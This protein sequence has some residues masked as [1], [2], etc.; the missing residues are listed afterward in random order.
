MAEV[1]ELCVEK[2]TKT[3]SALKDEYNTIRTGR[4]S[5][6]CVDKI[7]EVCRR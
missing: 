5:K 2:M 6:N 4:A 1:Q 7:E 3:I